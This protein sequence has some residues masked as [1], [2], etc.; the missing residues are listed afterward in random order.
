MIF[1]KKDEQSRNALKLI[2]HVLQAHQDMLE[3]KESEL[4]CIA[5]EEIK[6]EINSILE[7]KASQEKTFSKADLISQEIEVIDIKIAAIQYTYDYVKLMLKQCE[8]L[9]KNT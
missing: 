4:V 8:K 7:N 3:Q 6:N 1:I 5:S 2:Q 9:E